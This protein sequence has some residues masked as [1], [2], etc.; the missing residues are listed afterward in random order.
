[1]S[2]SRQAHEQI[3]RM[4][5]VDQRSLPER[6]AGLEHLW[7]PEVAERQRFERHHR[8]QD[9]RSA[10]R[11]A[12]TGGHDP[13]LRLPGVEVAEL[14]PLMLK[15][16]S[17]VASRFQRHTSP[18][19]SEGVTW[20]VPFASWLAVACS[21]WACAVTGAAAIRTAAHCTTK[22]IRTTRTLTLLIE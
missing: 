6:L 15:P 5:V 2:K 3:V 13:V 20:G 16:K 14:P 19:T 10:A 11:R 17:V 7:G 18:D 12:L 22:N 4:L 9:E 8:R 21:P 1:M